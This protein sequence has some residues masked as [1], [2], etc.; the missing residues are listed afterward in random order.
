MA[1]FG[2]FLVCFCCCQNVGSEQFCEIQ[3]VQ[4]NC[5]WWTCTP[6]RIEQFK[7]TQIQ[8]IFFKINFE[9]FSISWII[10]NPQ[11]SHWSTEWNIYSEKV[12]QMFWSNRHSM[13]SNSCPFNLFLSKFIVCPKPSC[14]LILTINIEISNFIMINLN[15]QFEFLKHQIFICRQSLSID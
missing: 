2:N 15:F 12:F 4:V 9:M 6:V 11:F 1:R 14:H 7:H 8:N 5:V 10:V 3:K 13:L